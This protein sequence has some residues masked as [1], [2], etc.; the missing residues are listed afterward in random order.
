M[1]HF[2]EFRVAVYAP[3]ILV[4]VMKLSEGMP[5]RVGIPSTILRRDRIGHGWP[6]ICIGVNE[7]EVG[8]TVR[9]RIPVFLFLGKIGSFRAGERYA[10]VAQ[11]ERH[12]PHCQTVS[13]RLWVRKD[14]SCIT[15]VNINRLSGGQRVAHSRQCIVTA[16]VRLGWVIFL[17]RVIHSG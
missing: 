5:A 9:D 8:S 7:A 2:S 16:F 12:P 1:R 13:P 17:G 14:I 6:G 11:A 3:D 4:G 15:V 10:N